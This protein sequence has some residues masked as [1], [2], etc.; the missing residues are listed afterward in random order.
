MMGAFLSLAASSDA[1]TVE[2]EVTFLSR[3]VTCTP[4][5]SSLGTYNSGD[6]KFFLLGVL[7]KLQD[8]VTHNDA[9]LPAQL[10]CCHLDLNSWC[11]DSLN[12]KRFSNEQNSAG[13]ARK[14]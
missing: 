7:E 10:T 4:V 2:E 3:S 11:W 5:V 14:T 9:R 1:T 12:S 13:T 8:I 6:S